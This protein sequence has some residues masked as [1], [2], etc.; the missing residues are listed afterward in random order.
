M[1]SLHC[2]ST[3]D[4]SYYDDADC[5]NMSMSS[6]VSSRS[7]S[8]SDE[9]VSE[10]LKSSGSSDNS[11]NKNSSDAKER[12]F[13]HDDVDNVIYSHISG[14]YLTLCRQFS[15]G[16]EQDNATM[17]EEPKSTANAHAISF[18]L[19]GVRAVT[20]HAKIVIEFQVMVCIDNDYYS[21]W[22]NQ[23]EFSSLLWNII[24]SSTSE[25]EIRR[26][27]RKRGWNISRFQ[28]YCKLKMRLFGRWMK[29]YFL[30][31]S[32]FSIPSLNQA[33]KQLRCLRKVLLVEFY[34][35]SS[36]EMLM[37]FLTPKATSS[38]VLCY[39]L[40]FKLW[41]DTLMLRFSLVMIYIYNA[42]KA[43]FFQK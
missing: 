28:H 20:Y 25:I 12:I 38:D 9:S 30:I 6:S 39:S 14:Q 10:M 3:D 7:T 34:E 18:S 32:S 33:R 15:N 8:L 37:L 29:F 40:V 2:R 23:H 21:S 42:L 35:I 22:K 13:T 24:F 11:V 17:Q 16:P 43:K 26:S 19:T 41:K 27:V 31:H 36:F 5:S 1:M 4:Y